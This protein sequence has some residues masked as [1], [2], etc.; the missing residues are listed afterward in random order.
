MLD[1]KAFKGTFVNRALPS[2]N[3]GSLEIT[4]T[5]PLII[6]CEQFLRLNRK[7]E[8][9]RTRTCILEESI[10]TAETGIRVKNLCFF[11]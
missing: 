2:L 11:S 8:Y 7:A 4:I 5:V 9:F 3:G 10:K 1:Q 6:I